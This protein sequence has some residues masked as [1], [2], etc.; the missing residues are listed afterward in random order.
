[1][2][3]PDTTSLVG[4]ATTKRYC[5]ICGCESQR[6]QIAEPLLLPTCFNK[7]CRARAEQ[8]PAEHCT[9]RMAHGEL[10]GAPATQMHL[11]GRRVCAFHS[12]ERY[13]RQPAA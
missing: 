10:C 13:E 5:Y 12:R 1:V 4:D 2:L 7:E 11:D 3:Q 6:R 9:A 8:L